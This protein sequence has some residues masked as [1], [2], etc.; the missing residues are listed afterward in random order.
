MAVRRRASAYSKKNPVVNTRHSK[1]QQYSYIKTVP[2]QKIVKFNMGDIR[3]F[4]DGKFKIKGTL[5]TEEN[6]QI[7]DLALEAVRQSI[8]KDLANLF[9]KNFFLRCNVFPHNVLRNNRVFSGAS[10]G[11][12]VQTGMTLGFGTS[13]GRAAIVRRGHPIF[14]AYFNGDMNIHKVKLFFKKTSPK[15]PCKSRI[16]FE[17]INN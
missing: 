6:I 4:E 13:E 14:T 8:H 1:K 2:S 12:R 3:S 15:L 5:S 10:K 16:T 9:Q 7:R 17:K 11:E